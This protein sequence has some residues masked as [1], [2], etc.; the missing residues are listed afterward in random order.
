MFYGTLRVVSLG[1]NNYCQFF[2]IVATLISY[3]N[4]LFQVKLFE[5]NWCYEYN[6]VRLSIAR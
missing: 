2:C 6:L 1:L 5:M 3:A 4:L